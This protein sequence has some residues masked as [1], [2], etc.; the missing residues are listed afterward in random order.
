MPRNTPKIVAHRGKRSHAPENT[1]ES[2]DLALGDNIYGVE[3]DVTLTSD[4][5]PIVIHQ[6]AL[7]VGPCEKKLVPAPIDGARLWTD[8]WS[9]EQIQKLDAGSWYGKEF[10][11]TQIPSLEQ[12]L[13]L[14]WEQIKVFLDIK[15]PNWFRGTSSSE[16]I[17]QV[18][19]AIAEPITTFSQAHNLSILSF[20]PTL[21]TECKKRFPQI[22]RT[23][24]VW[25]FDFVDQN[26]LRESCE[27]AEPEIVQFADSVILKTP[28]FVPFVKEQDLKCFVFETTPEGVSRNS[29]SWNAA[30]R[31][32]VW[33]RLLELEIDG[34]CCD[35]VDEFKNYIA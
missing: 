21:L 28:N 10:Q 29:N 25:T 7:E 31:L 9:Y 8:Q 3:F 22:P 2:I 13:N 12:V 27:Q 18:L 14:N 5:K 35:F 23:L 33:E 34:I 15:D 30:S 1:L 26:W 32:S 16:W 17:D 19:S 24:N 6:E 11:N 20:S 4:G